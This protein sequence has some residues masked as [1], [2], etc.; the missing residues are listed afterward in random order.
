MNIERMKKEVEI[1]KLTAG[2]METL[3]K[4]E[5]RKIEIKRMQDG[6]LTQ[7][8]RIEDLKA[9]LAEGDE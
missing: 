7:E 5:E 6:I 9:E 3:L 1:S 4:I 8:A 2:K